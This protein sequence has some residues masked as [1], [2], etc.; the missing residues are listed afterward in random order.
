LVA[1]AGHDKSPVRP[2]G[3]RVKQVPTPMRKQAGERGVDAIGH[4]R[5]SDGFGGPD[6]AACPSPK[7]EDRLRCAGRGI[8]SAADSRF[9]M[10][11]GPIFYGQNL[12]EESSNDWLAIVAFSS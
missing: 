8:A 1:P 7:R 12:F 3:P 5:G 9:S 4:A 11:C 2:S 10:G 6:Q